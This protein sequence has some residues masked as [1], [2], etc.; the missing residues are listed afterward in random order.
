MCEKYT[1]R[2]KEQVEA[3]IQ[4]A[5]IRPHKKKRLGYIYHHH[6]E[7]FDRLVKLRLI[8]DRITPLIEAE[9]AAATYYNS[10]ESD[11]MDDAAELDNENWSEENFSEDE[12]YDDLPF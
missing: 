8:E 10:L 7:L 2:L 5:R 9:E 1:G 12:D 11:D 3:A 4:L 6:R